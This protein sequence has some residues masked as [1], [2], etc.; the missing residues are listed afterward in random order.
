MKML[1]L[2]YTMRLGEI[3]VYILNY[4]RMSDFVSSKIDLI[5][6]IFI[7]FFYLNIFY[8]QIIKKID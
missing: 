3:E 5:L 2:K 4:P 7:L 6:F 8:L 1:K